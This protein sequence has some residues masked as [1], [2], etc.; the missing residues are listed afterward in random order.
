MNIINPYKDR[1]VNKL[2]RQDVKKISI[3]ISEDTF[4]KLEIE[5]MALNKTGKHWTRSNLIEAYINEEI[6]RKK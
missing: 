1:H 5:L 4:K 6:S 2:Y 3:S